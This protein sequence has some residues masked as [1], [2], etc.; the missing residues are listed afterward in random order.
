MN[1]SNI[2]IKMMKTCHITANFDRL[3]WLPSQIVS[4]LYTDNILGRKL[5]LGVKRMARELNL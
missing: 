1:R 3:V 4:V 2:I 5:S